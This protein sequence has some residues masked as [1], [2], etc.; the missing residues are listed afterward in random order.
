MKVTIEN[1]QEFASRTLASLGAPALDGAHMALGITTEL[2]ELLKGLKNQ[3]L[4]NIR[5]E[6]G[7]TLWY[8]ANECNIYGFRFENLYAK[9]MLTKLPERF[10]LGDLVDLHKK[11]MAYGK[12]M[13]LEKLEYHLLL[14]MQELIDISNTQGF[15]FERSLQINIEKLYAR[16]PDKFDSE[17]ALNRDL[18]KE[19]QILEG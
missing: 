19:Q 10:D 3:D 7:D 8:L 13:D 18:D 5:E 4:N 16:Y 12:T 14:L 11:E 9:C 2:S 17:K 6:H 1:Y 15:N